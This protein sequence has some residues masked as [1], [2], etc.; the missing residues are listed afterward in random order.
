MA[1][2]TA[3]VWQVITSLQMATHAKVSA[4]VQKWM[5]TINSSFYLLTF[6]VMYFY[7]HKYI[8]CLVKPLTLNKASKSTVAGTCCVETRKVG[9]LF[10]HNL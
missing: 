1:A 5:G 3:H 9:R 4:Y 6:M 10:I 8:V 2:T 7:E